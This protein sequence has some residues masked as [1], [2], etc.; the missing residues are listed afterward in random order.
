MIINHQYKMC[1]ETR[2]VLNYLDNIAKENN[3]SL[4]VTPSEIMTGD[5]LCLR[6]YTQ[7]ILNIIANKIKK[8]KNKTSKQFKCEY[9]L[10][11]MNKL[12]V[13]TGEVKREYQVILP[14]SVESFELISTYMPVDYN[15]KEAYM[16]Y[17]TCITHTL[18]NIQYAVRVA[19][20]NKVYNIN[21]INAILKKEQA[22]ANIKR[23]EI[24]DII[25]K[26][27]KSNVILYRPKV[28]N[29][30]EEVKSAVKH[31]EDMK[32]NAE[33]EAIFNG[34]YGDNDDAEI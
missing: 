8:V 14:P 16:I 18:S 32:I 28:N 26:E 21:Y 24:Q 29:T 3:V 19:Q 10:N 23:Q 12:F 7:P 25:A 30:E 9:W 20:Q 13:N 2:A 22:I 4:M 17:N 11:I 27:D 5:L 15:I 31:W 33:I 6:Y 34:L 1:R